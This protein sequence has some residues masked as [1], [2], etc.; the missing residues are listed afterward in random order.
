MGA[1]RLRAKAPS[2]PLVRTCAPK[3]SIVWSFISIAILQSTFLTDPKVDIPS[4]RCFSTMLRKHITGAARLSSGHFS[5]FWRI[6]D[7]P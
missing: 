7:L 4:A 2:G 6:Y 5:D 3:L 1:V